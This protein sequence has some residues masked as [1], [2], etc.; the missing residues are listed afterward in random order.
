MKKHNELKFLS[1]YVQ[2]SN[3]SLHFSVPM[4]LL[5]G[6][7]FTFLDETKAGFRDKF[8]VISVLSTKREGFQEGAKCSTQEV[9]KRRGKKDPNEIR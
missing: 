2:K 7:Y 4:F 5:T 8:I 9:M 1:Q 6:L 3:P